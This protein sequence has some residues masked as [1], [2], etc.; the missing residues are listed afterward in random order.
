[1]GRGGR[2]GP[3][4][5]DVPFGHRLAYEG[6]APS[7]SQVVALRLFG[8]GGRDGLFRELAPEAVASAVKWLWL[9]A[10]PTVVDLTVRGTGLGGRGATLGLCAVANESLCCKL[11]VIATIVGELRPLGGGGLEG[12]MGSVG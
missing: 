10:S 3:G 7:A 5:W 1:M 8:G 12:R 6:G 11:F 4:G 9:V 2:T